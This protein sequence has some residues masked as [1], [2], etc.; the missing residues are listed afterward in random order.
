L[1]PLPIL[2]A[3]AILASLVPTAE[4]QPTHDACQYYW[5]QNVTASL[6]LVAAGE[7]ELWSEHPGC[8]VAKSS[9]QSFI[10]TATFTGPIIVGAATT[11]W[12]VGVAFTG[13]TLGTIGVNTATLAATTISTAVAILTMTSNEC[14]GSVQFRNV[15]GAPPVYDFRVN[16]PF[17]IRVEQPNIFFECAATQTTVNAYTPAQTCLDPQVNNFNYLCDAPAVAPDAFNPA[18]TTCNDPNLILSGGLTVTDDADGWLITGI[19]DT[20]QEIQAIADALAAGLDVT[21]CPETAP[22]YHVLSGAVDTNTTVVQ[23]IDNQT[24][25]AIIPD[26]FTQH[27]DFP[28]VNTEGLD[29]GLILFWIIVLLFTTYQRWLLAA[30][31]AVPGLFDAIFPDAIPGDFTQWLAFVLLG[32]VL[33]VAANRFS[34]AYY[35]PKPTGM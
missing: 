19:P 5:H 26:E 35:K 15:I 25:N 6:G 20:Q 33:E 29:W 16:I 11:T 30:G 8:G 31:F 17:N 23:N 7:N 10:W 18:S 21:I 22:C 28:V 27:I 24:L 34:W 3:A 14:R 1:K 2:L 9:T 13:C 4:A 12:N 32:F